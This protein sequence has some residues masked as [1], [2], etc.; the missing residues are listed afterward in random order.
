MEP[1]HVP[2]AQLSQAL[3]GRGEQH[4]ATKTDRLDRHRSVCY[5]TQYLGHVVGCAAEARWTS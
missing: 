4:P 2:L 1:E 5:A 3:S